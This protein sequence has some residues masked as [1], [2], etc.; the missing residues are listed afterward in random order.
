MPLLNEGICKLFIFKEI[1]LVYF[2]GKDL[3][4]DNQFF[5]ASANK[6]ENVKVALIYLFLNY[7]DKKNHFKP[8]QIS[9]LNYRPDRMVLMVF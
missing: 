9:F 8:L 1:L 5:D 4:F 7:Q 6:S 3:S 2:P